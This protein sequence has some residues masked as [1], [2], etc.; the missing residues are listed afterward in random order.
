MINDEPW[1]VAV[2]VCFVLGYVNGRDAVHAHTE[3][4]QRNTVVIR[5]GNRGNPSRLAVSK[6]GLFALILGS[7][8]PTARRF[9]AW[10]TD[11]VLPAL[12]KDG[13]YVMGEEKV[14]T[15]EMSPDDLIKRGLLRP[16]I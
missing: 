4:H 3:P 12:E 1:F 13:A 10:V 5:D 14:A 6:G 15:G 9:K 16:L 8:L 7:H 11:V 2:D